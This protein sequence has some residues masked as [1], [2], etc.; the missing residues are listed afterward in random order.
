MLRGF[1]GG[2]VSDFIALATGKRAFRGSKKRIATR[3]VGEIK[4][5]T[6][7]Y[8]P[9]PGGASEAVPETVMGIRE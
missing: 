6:T 9:I 2:R 5:T 1:G 3:R 7:S 4:W 8:I